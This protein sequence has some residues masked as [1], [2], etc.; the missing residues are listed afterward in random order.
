MAKPEKSSQMGKRLR[1]L[2][3]QKNVSQRE[4]SVAIDVAEMTISR[5]ER[6]VREDGSLAIL[7]KLAAYYGV[8]LDWLTTEEESIVV[9]EEASVALA[10]LME[11]WPASRRTDPSIGEPPT[12]EEQKWI[13]HDV[14]WSADRQAGLDIDARLIFD[15]IMTRRRQGKVAPRPRVAVDVDPSFLRPGD[16]APKRKRS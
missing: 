16:E 6:G 14:R 9:D 11:D 1:A 15:R 10:Q 13:L 12:E 4:V 3:D 5:Y 7:Q 8:D 2:R